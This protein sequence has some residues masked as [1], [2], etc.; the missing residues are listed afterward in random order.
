MPKVV[1]AS[2]SKWIRAWLYALR[3]IEERGAVE[4]AHRV[5]NSLSMIFRYAIATGRAQRDPAADLRGALS[6]PDAGHMPTMTDPARIAQLLRDMYGYRGNFTTCAALRIAPLVFVRPG[7]LRLAEWVEFDLVAAEWRIPAARM[8]LRKAAKR[9]AP[10][11]IVPLSRQ[12]CA[13]LE[14]V[15]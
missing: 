14:D 10:A 2:D 12:A 7:E 13:M 3:R 11:H 8:K 9:A 6:V 5:R 1:T 4:T 15:R